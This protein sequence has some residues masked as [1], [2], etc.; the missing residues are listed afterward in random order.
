MTATV[1]DPVSLIRDFFSLRLSQRR[2]LAERYG[3]TKVDP[4]ETD[5]DFG[6][7]TIMAVVDQGK[8]VEFAILVEAAKSKS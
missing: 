3:V 8:Q 6:K 1:A 4:K 7:R 5:L 2:F